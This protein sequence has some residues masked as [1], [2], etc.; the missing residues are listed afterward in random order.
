[1]LLVA[2]CQVEF[3]EDGGNMFQGGSARG[4]ATGRFDELVNVGDAVFEQ[5]ANR[6]G[7]A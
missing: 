5:V 3:H 2:R 1:V 7:V 6:P 4:D